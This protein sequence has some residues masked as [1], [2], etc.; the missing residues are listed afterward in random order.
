VLLEK[1]KFLFLPVQID[2]KVKSGRTSKTRTVSV[3]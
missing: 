1:A 2:K 3:R